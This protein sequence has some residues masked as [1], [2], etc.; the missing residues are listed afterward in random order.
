MV[1]DRRHREDATAGQ[2][3]G[4]D[5]Q[6]HG[7]GLHHKNPADDGEE[8]LLVDADRHHRHR[9]AER[10]RAGVPHEDLGG[11]A[12]E[13]EKAE[14]GTKKRRAKDHQF[15]ASG[16]LRQKEVGGKNRMAGKVGKEAEDE[17]DGEEATGGKTVET[18]G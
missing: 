13:P 14:A 1:V 16:N 15:L 4:G 11:M 18:V 5:L 12:V 8:K 17:G 3:E 7:N 10:Q 6:D 9:P 2:F